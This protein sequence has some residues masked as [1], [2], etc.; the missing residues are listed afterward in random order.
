M[1]LPGMSS[2][3]GARL[4]L[5]GYSDR[6]INDSQEAAQEI[7]RRLGG[8]ALAIDQ[9]AAYIAYRKIPPRRLKEFLQTYDKQREK[10]LT[11]TP[12]NFW[13][14]TSMQIHGEENQSKAINA[15]T[16]WEIS[17]ELLIA[18]NPRGKDELKYFLT[19]SSF[20]DPA[21][22]EESLFANY[23]NDE[24]YRENSR[25]LGVLG[26]RDDSEERSLTSQETLGE[27]DADRFWDVLIKMH[28]L[29]LLQTVENGDEGAAF[30]L[31]PLVRDWLQIR[32]R[33][34][35]YQDYI[36][37]SFRVA[38]SS[39]VV[40][41]EG[42]L[43]DF[44]KLSAWLTPHI[45]ACMDNDKRF[46]KPEYLIGSAKES[47]GMASIL[48]RLY[49]TLGRFPSA[50]ELL[51]RVTSNEDVDMCYVD[52]L[53]RVLHNQGMY[54]EVVNI[55]HQKLQLPEEE[56]GLKDLQRL[57]FMSYFA[58]ALRALNKRD[59]AHSMFC[60]ILQLRQ[61]IRGKTHVKTLSSMNQL[62]DSFHSQGSYVESENLAREA[63][64]LSET[65]SNTQVQRLYS[66][67]TLAKALHGHGKYDEAQNIQRQ[68][69]QGYHEMLGMLGKDHPATLSAIHN[70]AWILEWT[71]APESAMLYRQ[72]LQSSE[73][74][75]RKGH[76]ATVNSMENLAILLWKKG[77]LEEAVILQRRL[78]L[79]S[80]DSIGE[81]DP[82][83][84]R[85][86]HHLALFSKILIR[87]GLKT[88][89]VNCS[90]KRESTARRTS[91]YAEKYRYSCEPTLENGREGRS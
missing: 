83:T 30:S 55:C 33:S 37:A 18:D 65:V 69:V 64:R 71:N 41:I 74:V 32:E 10:I 36:M 56:L 22:I 5:R 57:E 31:H 63:V 54:E 87:M 81:E 53:C 80:Q 44:F 11:Y 42:T 43:S 12:S 88:C 67:Y 59:E 34:M 77:E 24:N 86:M 1:Q 28:E 58:R 49:L 91:R 75:L 82:T 66:M 51:R 14:Y 8:L 26:T 89:I 17:L 45:D 15:F 25:W 6:E 20:F 21:R 2:D 60:Q 62:A 68:V 52:Q 84:L 40:Y 19:L 73:K 76:P 46:S 29:S 23:W 39:A 85:R 9:A 7:V 13:E 3:E 70:L 38:A 16:T 35:N 50:E 90:T 72:V 78:V 27:W 4:L 48:A 61:E 79:L 47:H